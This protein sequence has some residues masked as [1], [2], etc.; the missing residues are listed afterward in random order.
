MSAKHQIHP[1]YI[2]KMIEDKKYSEKSIISN[3]NILKKLV[4]KKFDIDILNNEYF[5]SLI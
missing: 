1:T 3:I 4:S 2:Q 5:I